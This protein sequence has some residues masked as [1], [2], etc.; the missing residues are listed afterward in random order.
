[1]EYEAH[2]L[3]N[4]YS[5]YFFKYCKNIR[6]DIIN[7]Y[8]IDFVSHDQKNIV[9]SCSEARLVFFSKHTWAGRLGTPTPP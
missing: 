7:D 9:P 8:F 4:Y 5:R 6:S 2:L 1:M 3:V